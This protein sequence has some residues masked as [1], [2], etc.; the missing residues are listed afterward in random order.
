MTQK[1]HGEFLR[2]LLVGGVQT[3]LSYLFFLLLLLVLAYPVAY[4]VSYCS[5]IVLSYFL[6]TLFVFREKV[7]WSSFLKFPLV[8]LMQYLLGLALIWFFV[9]HLGIPPSWAMLGVIALTVPVTF[10]TSRFVLKKQP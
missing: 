7:R 10:L 8:Y 3:V 9:R 1:I 6:N 5:G 4:S 2:F